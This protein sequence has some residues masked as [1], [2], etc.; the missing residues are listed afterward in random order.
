MDRLPT[1]RFLGGFRAVKLRGYGKASKPV[2]EM[3]VLNKQNETQVKV[4]K[5]QWDGIG[6][7]GVKG[8]VGHGHHFSVSCL[9]ALEK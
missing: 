5:W 6:H 4:G 2:G 1:I 8:W 3:A 9:R 7:H